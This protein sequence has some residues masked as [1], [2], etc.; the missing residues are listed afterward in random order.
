MDPVGVDPIGVE[1]TARWLNV[2][3]LGVSPSPTPG[4]AGFAVPGV[5]AFAT[6][7]PSARPAANAAAI[8]IVTAL[9]RELPEFI[10]HAFLSSY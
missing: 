7:T 10:C 3:T 1:V 4:A 6:G 5:S 9:L 2:G 8:P